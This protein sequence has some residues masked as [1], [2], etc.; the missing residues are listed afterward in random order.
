MVEKRFVYVI[1]SHSSATQYY[2]GLTS[3]VMTRLASHNAGDS[4]HTQRYRPWKL[5]VVMAFATEKRA[6]A[7]EKYLKSSAG[8]AFLKHHLM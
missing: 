5:V 2:V 7:F 3:N 8:S 4:P 1:Q 6:A